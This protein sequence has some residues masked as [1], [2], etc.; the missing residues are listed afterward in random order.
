MEPLEKDWKVFRKKLAGWQESY[1]ERLAVEYID[2]L[3]QELPASKKFWELDK[4]IKQDKK[5]PGVQL[6]KRRSTMVTDILVMIDD[7]VIGMEA[8]DGF[9]EELIDT[10]KRMRGN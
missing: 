1:M 7:G 4:R 10:I 9:S 6:E 2:L 5:S 3:N 8:L